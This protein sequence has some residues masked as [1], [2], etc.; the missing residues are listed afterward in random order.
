MVTSVTTTMLLPLLCLLLL[1]TQLGVTLL[2]K[3][4]L[5]LLLGEPNNDVDS[6]NIT[7]IQHSSN[8]LQ[9]LIP[10]TYDLESSSNFDNYLQE[11]GVSYFLRQLAMLAQPQVTFSKNCTQ[12]GM[13]VNMSSCVWSIYTDAGI[14]THQ[15]LFTLGEEV[16]KTRRG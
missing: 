11:M 6:H 2:V 16:T 5:L 4:V 13:I 3:S 1:S 9:Q 10:G 8:N 15:I 12:E 14:K 7:A